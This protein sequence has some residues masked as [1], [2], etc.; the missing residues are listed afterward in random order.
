MASNVVLVDTND[1]PVGTF[2][3]ATPSRIRTGTTGFVKASAGKLFGVTAVNTNAA[4][5]VLHI[6]DK[7][8]APT[9]NSDTPM[10]TIP[11]A[12]S[13][14]ANQGIPLGMPG[15]AFTTGIAWAYTTDN[16]AVP[17]TAATSGELFANF[18]YA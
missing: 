7:A 12:A 17:V 16:A 1:V 4:A 3:G 13:S 8:S 5:R 2:G 6:Y 11:L 10:V 14:A 15:I 9:L 18:F